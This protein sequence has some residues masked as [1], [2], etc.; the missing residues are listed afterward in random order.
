[1][2]CS[3]TRIEMET[4]RETAT[5]TSVSFVKGCRLRIVRCRPKPLA[6]FLV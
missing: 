2:R 4:Y 3:T 1:M 6:G 5:P